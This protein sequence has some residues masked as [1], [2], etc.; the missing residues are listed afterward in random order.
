M[1]QRNSRFLKC[2][3]TGE[4]KQFYISGDTVINCLRNPNKDGVVLRL[5]FVEIKDKVMKISSSP[6]EALLPKV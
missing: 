2:K 5:S 6:D 1:L 4:H 3:V